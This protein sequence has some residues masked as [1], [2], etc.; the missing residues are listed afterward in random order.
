M[1]VGNQENTGEIINSVSVFYISNKAVL[2][3]CTFL[4]CTLHIAHCTLCIVTVPCWGGV[5]VLFDFLNKFL[6]ITSYTYYIV[7]HRLCNIVHRV[8]STYRTSPR[9]NKR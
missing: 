6:T 9:N 5:H 2:C 7:H 4:H 1:F 8:R 3:H